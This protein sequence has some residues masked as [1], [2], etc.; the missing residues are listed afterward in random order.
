MTRKQVDALRAPVNQLSQ[1]A[2]RAERE[3]RE[4]SRKAVLL[5]AKLTESEVVLFGIRAERPRTITFRAEE[6]RTLQQER[7]AEAT[8]IRA[9]AAKDRARDAEVELQVKLKLIES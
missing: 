4:A 1:T 3:A 2:A 9:T 6:K 5:R 8:Q 7:L